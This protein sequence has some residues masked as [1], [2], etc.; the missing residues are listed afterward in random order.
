MKL[1]RRAAIALLALFLAGLSAVALFQ[2]TLI[3]NAG[4]ASEKEL[5]VLAG[6]R[7]FTP[8]RT[9]DGSLIGWTRVNPGAKQRLL[10]FHGNSGHALDRARFADA[11]AGWEVWLAEHPGFGAR[12]G[13]LTRENLLAAGKAAVENLALRDSRPLFLLG[14]SVGGGT[15]CA[16]AGALPDK[17]QGV[18]ALIPFARLEEVVSTRF[19]IIPAGLLLRDKYDNLAAL[20]AYHGPLAVVVAE[21]DE[22]VT[23]AQGRKLY[24]SYAGPKH[25][26]ILPG[27]K[28]GDYPLTADSQWVTEAAA[29]LTV[30]RGQA[31]TPLD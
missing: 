9:T 6:Q 7:S 8:W 13:P 15:A 28:H 1:L 30:S 27:C 19:P 14:E 23:P 26:W 22:V 20:F 3:Y 12:D 10:V 18:I 2:N 21:Q 29:F 11:F 31:E 16:V 17:V 24:E 4:R 5:L 25:L